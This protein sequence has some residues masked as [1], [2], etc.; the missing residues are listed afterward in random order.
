MKKLIYPIILFFL[1]IALFLV[2]VKS[3]CSIIFEGAYHQI[4]M[5]IIC[6]GFVTIC[7]IHV[8]KKI[9]R[10]TRTYNLKNQ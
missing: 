10:L 4:P 9:D 7:I 3:T 2:G 5:C 8:A 6:F 1:V